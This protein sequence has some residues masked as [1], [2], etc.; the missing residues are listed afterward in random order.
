MR[1]SNPEIYISLILLGV[2]VVLQLH[3]WN[4]AVL[5][6]VLILQIKLA[7]QVIHLLIDYHQQT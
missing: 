5:D 6:A 2:K 3:G 4:L 7:I 1:T